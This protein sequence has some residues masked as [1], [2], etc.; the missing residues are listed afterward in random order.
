MLVPRT[1]RARVLLGSV[2][3]VLVALAVVAAAV[4]GIATQHEIDVLGTRLASEAALASDLS[5]V[6]L[7][8]GDSDALD[9]LAKRIAL[10]ASVRVTFVAADGTV[11]GESDEDRRMMENHAARPEIAS[12]LAGGE[13]R[14]VR[15]S[16]TVGRDLLYVAVPVRAG[17]RIVGVTRLALPL[18][19]V[20]A[21]AAR[22]SLSLLP[23]ALLAA[24]ASILAAWVIQRAITRPIELLTERAESQDAS[25]DIRGP[26]EIERL[27]AEIQD[28]Q[29]QAKA[30]GEAKK[31]RDASA[32]RKGGAKG[33]AKK[34][35]GNG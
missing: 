32:I 20:D 10:A 5:R 27:A 21:L 15:Y 2:L 35:S 1:I 26:V 34:E 31:L 23:A 18:V 29:A 4:P 16:S 24:T 6:L 8:G 12:A 25:F 22:L 9:L 13:G 33:S 19:A 14:T 28:L 3:T 11:V 7:V 17:D 30:A